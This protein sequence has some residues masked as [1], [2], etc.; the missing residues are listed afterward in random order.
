MPA[1]SLQCLAECNWR[2]RR[3]VQVPEEGRGRVRSH[4]RS[5]RCSRMSAAASS[6]AWR[7]QRGSQT[8][9]ALPLPEVWG[10][11]REQLQQLLPKRPVPFGRTRPDFG[12]DVRRHILDPHAWHGASCVTA[13]LRRPG[14]GAATRWID[15][16]KGGDSPELLACGYLWRTHPHPARRLG[17]DAQS[18]AS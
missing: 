5:P 12:M 11:L 8:R 13:Q 18:V 7:R 3:A 10:L 9:Q 14:P 2:G 1:L 15:C 16:M 4:H 17:P 6:G